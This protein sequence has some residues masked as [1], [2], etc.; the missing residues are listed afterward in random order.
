MNE[1]TPALA[2]AA[3]ATAIGIVTGLVVL[4][5]EHLIDELLHELVEAPAWVPAAVLIA[6]AVVTAIVVHYL[7]GGSSSTTEVYVEEFHLDAP[8][9]ESKYAPGRLLGALT[10]LGSGAPLG[11][12]G[13]AVY[14]GT[15]AAAVVHRRR[16]AMVAST[17]HALLVAGAAA[18]IAAVFK[19]PAAGAIFA[20]E[21]PFLGRLAH[22]RVLPAIFGSAAGFLTMATVDGFSPEL[23]VPLI[24]LTYGR[25]AMCAVLGLIVGIAAMGVIA[26]IG[27]AERS[28]DRWSAST[29]ALLAG[30]LLAGVYGIGRA[31]TD[32]PI[33]IT[34]GNSVIDWAIQ[35]DHAVWVLVVVFL[36]R[37]VGPAISIGGGGV[38]GLFIPLMASGAVV[39]RLFADA[40][41]SEELALFVVVG[42]ACM[43]GG[44]YAIPL[45]AAVF[46]AEYTGQ[47][48]VIVPGLVAITVTRLVVGSRSVSPAQV[49]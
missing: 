22:E 20:M 28:H 4:A 36:I 41:S 43:L 10:T 19:A 30:L 17:H 2:R 37:A 35:P 18:G 7:G 16:P 27:L 49:V 15:I 38:G 48:S 3:L 33:A 39:G 31:A 13:P 45:T 8:R 42:A 23:E 29:R 1:R 12:E 32:E 5:L 26:L 6:G 14:T 47:A 44:G 34:S 40:A 11:M 9:I 21:V 46:I 25:V 24:E